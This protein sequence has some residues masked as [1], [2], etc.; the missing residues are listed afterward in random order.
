M[1]D[2]AQVSIRDNP[3]AEK[4]LFV[5]SAI[6]GL[7]G[8]SVC[9]AMIWEAS[10]YRNGISDKLVPVSLLITLIVFPIAAMTSLRLYGKCR[11]SFSKSLRFVVIAWQ[12]LTLLAWV[13]AVG[14]VIFGVFVW[15]S[16]G[17]M[18]NGENLPP[19]FWSPFAW[20]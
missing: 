8:P 9:A 2:T 13:F 11:D 19:P 10:P 12:T 14:V 17:F 20:V 1:T 6:T 16:G 15:L 3:T 7:L 4:L 5:V 18:W